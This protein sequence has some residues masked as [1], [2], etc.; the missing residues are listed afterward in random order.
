MCFG[1][2]FGN[3]VRCSSNTSSLYPDVALSPEQKQSIG[4]A[5]TGAAA[6]VLLSLRQFTAALRDENARD[7]RSYARKI[8]VALD[9]VLAVCSE[10]GLY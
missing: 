4:D 8:E 9:R 5:D 2:P 6:D 3:Y 10:A 1:A 7:A